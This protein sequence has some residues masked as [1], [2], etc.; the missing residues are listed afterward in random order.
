MMEKSRAKLIAD[1]I[2][3]ECQSNEPLDSRLTFMAMTRATGEFLAH[4]EG[5]LPDARH[6]YI[7]A[8]RTNLRAAREMR[9]TGR[10]GE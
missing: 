5:S 9:R 3:A 6:L 4:I 10:R 2:V 8:L 7:T 1:E